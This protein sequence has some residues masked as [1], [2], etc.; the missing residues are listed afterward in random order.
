[1]ASSFVLAT[2]LFFAQRAGA[3]IP[4]HVSLLLMVATT[5][6]I[7]MAATYLTRPTDDETLRRFYRRVRPAGPGWRAV[8]AQCP[9]AAPPD[10]LTIAFGGWV[11]GVALVY[12]ALFGVGHLLLGHQRLGMVILAIA[13]AGAVALGRLL[14]KMWRASV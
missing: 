13:L 14:P 8:R 9:H 2:A 4:S 5:T 6:A 7:W 1:M 10:D 12:G 11:A 3:D